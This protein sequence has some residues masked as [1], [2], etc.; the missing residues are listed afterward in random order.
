MTEGNKIDTRRYLPTIISIFFL[1]LIGRQSE[2]DSLH[3][4]NK[5]LRR[6]ERYLR[7]DKQ[8]I[9][10]DNNMKRSNKKLTGSIA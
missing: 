8:K 6:N 9:N 5:R 4:V 1:R 2:N 10:L 7:I 3:S